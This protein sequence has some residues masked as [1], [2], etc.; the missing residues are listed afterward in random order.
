MCNV[1][2]AISPLSANTKP[3]GES[4]GSGISVGGCSLFKVFQVGSSPL[5][6]AAL[7]FQIFYNYII[8]RPFRSGNVNFFDHFCRKRGRAKTAKKTAKSFTGPE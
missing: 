7:R 2:Q 5:W 6:Q 8:P 1:F 3:S 4:E